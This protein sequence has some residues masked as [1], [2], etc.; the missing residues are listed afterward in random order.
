MRNNYGDHMTELNTLFQIFNNLS[1]S[2]KK[3]FLKKIK[4]ENLPN[5]AKAS[6][7]TN[8]YKCA[9]CNSANIVKNGTVRGVQ[10]YL[11]RDCHKTFTPKTNTILFKTHYSDAVWRKYINCMMNGMSIRKSAKACGINPDTAFKWRH[12]ILDSL[13]TMHKNVK[14]NGVVE[15]DETFFPLSFK[16]NHNKSNFKLPRES[17]HR[18]KSNHK[19]G[20]SSDQVCV[21]CAINLNGLSKSVITNL[22]KPTVKDLRKVFSRSIAENSVLVTDRNSAYNKIANEHNLQLVQIK[23]GKGSKGT[24]NIAKINSYHCILKMFIIYNFKGVSTKYL[25]NY[26]IWNNIKNYALGS[27]EEKEQ[28]FADFVFTNKFCENSHDV[29]KRK[30]IPV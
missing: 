12:K 22:G 9:H 16:G 8:I 14:L 19:R 20:I 11:C 23:S 3:A 2:E 10:R 26:L 4:G 7:I 21:P 24:F 13:Q 1:E 27:E 6:N 29:S 25:N 30:A 17:H 28:I 15:A 18:G 5:L